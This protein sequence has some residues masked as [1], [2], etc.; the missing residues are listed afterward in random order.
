MRKSDT[1][2]L[3]ALLNTE[4]ESTS[5]FDGSNSLFGS[6]RSDDDDFHR[7]KH[8]SA[9]LDKQMTQFQVRD[10]P[11][12]RPSRFPPLDDDDYDLSNLNTPLLPQN[13]RQLQPVDCIF[14][15]VSSPNQLPPSDSDYLRGRP[16]IYMWR[17]L[18]KIL[19]S[20]F[21]QV[22]QAYFKEHYMLISPRLRFYF[23]I[24]P[25]TDKM[26]HLSTIRN[27]IQGGRALFHYIGFGFPR[28]NENYMYAVD[29]K[30]GGFVNYAVKSLFENLKAP[31][32]FIFDCSN[33]AAPMSTL[34]KISNQKS[35]EEPQQSV[36]NIYMNRTIDWKDWFCLCATDFD[37]ELP[38]DP[39]LPKDFLTS[40]LL[41]PV[42]MAV[43]CH[44][45]QYYRTSI[46]N[47]HFPLDQLK[48]PLMDGNSPIHSTLVQTLSAI[49]DA[50]AVDSLTP[51]L[52]RLLFRKDRVTMIIFQRFL[53]A[54][55]LLRP[56]QVHP[57]STPALPDL[58]THPLWQHWRTIIDMAIS[59]VLTP[60]PSLATDL[61][62]RAKDSVK[63]FL[64]RKEEKLISPAHLMLLFHVPQN[65]T[66]R[67]DAF[68]LL[69]RFAS[70]SDA[71]RNLLKRTALF[72]SVF[73]ALVSNENF[74]PNVF[75]ALCYL[76]IS[77]LQSSPRFVNDIRREFDV[78]C[79]PGRLFDQSLPMYT[80]TLVA[81]IIA[82]VLPHSEGIRSVS[83]S[84][85]FLV[86]MKKLL[87][88]S[89][90]PLSLWSLIIQRRM[91][92]SFGSELKNFFSISM[93]IQVASFAM[94]SSPEVRAASLAT[95][96]CFLQQKADMS[97]A[98]LFGLTM[99]TAFD[100][101]FLVRFNFVLFLSRFL[102]IYQ[103]KIAGKSPLGT[104]SHQCFRALVNVW[105]GEDKP[106]ESLISD[107]HEISQVVDSICRSPDFISKFVQIGLLLVD[108]LTDDP[109][110]SVRSSAQELRNFVQI[111]SGFKQRIQLSTNL[112]APSRSDR[113]LNKQ[114]G[115]FPSQNMPLFDDFEA[116]EDRPALCES[117]GDAMYKVCLRQIVA[118]GCSLKC[119]EECAESPN[120]TTLPVAPVSHMPNTKLVV[121]S[122]ETL[123][124]EHGK[125][126]I[127]SYNARSLSL[128]V[129]TTSGSILY[130]SEE[131]Q[132]TYINNFGNERITAL[133]VVD[134]DNELVVA[135]T[136]CGCAYVWEPTHTTPRLCFRADSP[137]R[138]GSMP[139][140][141]TPHSYNKILT[142]RGNCGTIRLWDICAQRIVSEWEAGANQPVTA[143][144]VHPSDPNIC[145][146]GHL[147]GLIVTID[148]RCKSATGP[149]NVDAPKINEKILKI[150][151]NSM[152][153]KTFWAGTSKGS[154]MR[155]EN[156]NNLEIIKE[157]P[158]FTDFDVH[159]TSPLAAISYSSTYPVI[160]S[161]EMKTLHNL[162]NVEHGS[163]CAFHPAL[164]VVAFAGA[165]G[166][167]IEYELTTIK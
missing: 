70:T 124:G 45:I 4:E 129:G 166:E 143:I 3:V 134:W 155:W 42:T 71:A 160:V 89:D 116:S 94:H 105:I 17:D 153:P 103:D 32:W 109:H 126:V 82:S 147:N 7:S 99:L 87:A 48:S 60:H 64:E 128:A 5:S 37:E 56:Y 22:V 148:L 52:Y 18:S 131:N 76:T 136:E 158:T 113:G 92:D 110:P 2:D 15:M 63:G 114:S 27:D 127:C 135:G 62:V 46:V 111:Q 9:T 97:N 95:I 88:T 152:G 145:A 55:Y 44:T 66:Y 23:Q 151:G 10:F 91:F 119:C 34:E 164:P 16:F 115:S 33:A 125:P 58:S 163:A 123:L 38:I 93:H 28:V 39:H 35:V 24:S 142:S 122:K 1:I 167:I 85:D 21:M 121:R 83:V 30:T 57:K 69:A 47:D 49:T 26:N 43:V 112:S 161:S 40:C 84:S 132:K 59:S 130:H 81:A 73:S 102:T 146:A 154:I 36:S 79:F 144:A 51:D 72:N 80:R 162:K 137:S 86:S 29:P 165:S 96:P 107:F 90:A 140:V 65:A 138:C 100:A 98:Q 20:A 104:F 31:S 133:C 50:I 19:S 150:V 117:G 12:T 67:N 106:F 8:F 108:Y 61:F 11:N 54:Q 149:T 159:P 77:L 118:A 156:L 120:F 14:L 41:T 139:L 6:D 53:L 68:V 74:D 101:S 141:L 75:H 78:S 157:G 13:E 25:T